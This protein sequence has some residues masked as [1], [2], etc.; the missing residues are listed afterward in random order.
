MSESAVSRFKRRR[1]VVDYADGTSLE[2]SQPWGFTCHGRALCPDGKIRAFRGG[3]ADTAF[4]I[5]ARVSAKGTTVSGFVCVETRDGFTVASD[6]DPAV[7]KFQ[8]YTYR[9]NHALVS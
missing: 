8:P 6:D 7:V 4:S 2:F 1:L 5:P 9:R 3:I